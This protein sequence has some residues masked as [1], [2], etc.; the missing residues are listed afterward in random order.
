V[1]QFHRLHKKILAAEALDDEAVTR[2]PQVLCAAGAAVRSKLVIDSVS[3]KDRN[4][5]CPKGNPSAKCGQRPAE[6][7]GQHND[8]DVAR[9]DPGRARRCWRTGIARLASVQNPAAFMAR[10]GGYRPERAH[11]DEGQSVITL[12]LG[13]ELRLTSARDRGGDPGTEAVSTT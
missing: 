12:N 3:G 7:R 4:D 5:A 13:T 6:G 9:H 2:P 1:H 10:S 8:A 11:A